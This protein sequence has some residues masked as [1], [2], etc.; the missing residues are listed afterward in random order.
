MSKE[1]NNEVEHGTVVAERKPETKEP[2]M[3][4]VMLLNDD[5]TPMDFVVAVLKQFFHKSLEQA[6]KVMLQV[7]Y[8]GAGVAGIYR[9]E[10]AET[11]VVSVNEYAKEHGH[12]LM[13]TMQENEK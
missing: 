6:T 2:P 13:C 8:D 1:K 12:P 4:K 5:Y 10:I 7:H 11:K 9:A 3:Y